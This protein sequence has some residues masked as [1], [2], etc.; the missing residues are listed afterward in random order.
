MPELASSMESLLKR[1]CIIVDGK[2]NN[3]KMC[4]GTRTA[5]QHTLLFEW[6]GWHKVRLQL[7]DEVRWHQQK[8]R[9]DSKQ[10]LW[11][12]GIAS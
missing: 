4:V 7:E 12:S 1:A 2:E 9:K 8:A 6:K 3:S 10:Q 11:Q 5:K